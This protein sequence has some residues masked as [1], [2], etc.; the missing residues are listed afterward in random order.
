M[1]RLLK[2]FRV[3]LILLILSIGMQT[4]TLTFA[5]DDG[6]GLLVTTTIRVNLR[7][8]PGT[9]WYILGI[10]E[11]GEN[12]RVDGRAPYLDNLWVRGITAG[13][14]IGWIYAE[15]I[16]TPI[17]QV[18]SLPVVWVDDP[19]NL[20]PAP[21]NAP[22]APPPAP[23]AQQQPEAAPAEPRA[24]APVDPAAQAAA[25]AAVAPGETP[26]YIS[27]ITATARS[28]YLNGQ[29]LGNRANIF[30]KIG[31]SIT[32]A[33]HFLS[34][35]GRGAYQLGSYAHLQPV[36]DYFSYDIART[37]NSFANQS[38][39]ANNGWTTRTALDPNAANG[40]V[41][42][43]GEAPVAC[44]LRV[45]RPSVALIMLGTNDTAALDQIAFRANLS[46]IVQTAIDRGVIPV[47]STIPPRPGADGAV[48]AFNQIIVETARSYDTPLW[49]YHSQMTALPAA[50]LSI[51]RL[52]PSFPPG[53]HP[54]DFGA[55]ATFTPENLNYGYTVRNL[56]ALQVLDAIWRQVMY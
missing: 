53:S 37:D 4:N 10:V 56:G 23:P 28:I 30:S 6:P 19:F 39:S 14:Q 17:D 11:A 27:G 24:V 38:L 2:L 50:G 43:V 36:I 25:P 1:P 46:T 22:A 33:P 49:D 41:C 32:V 44:E 8:G 7:D 51:D 47:L 48:G 3:L 45:V 54:Q 31:D 52:H 16:N 15:H 21:A 55:A 9:D 42:T 12:F 29:R 40:G 18:S 20:P 13:G 26:P 34:P 5:Q 35:I